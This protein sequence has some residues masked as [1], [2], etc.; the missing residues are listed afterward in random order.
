MF[1][2]K[3]PPLPGRQRPQAGP[4]R[5]NSAVFSYANNRSVRPASGNVGRDLKAQE[6]EAKKSPAAVRRRAQINWFKRGPTLVAALLAGLLLLNS[7]FLST[8]PRIV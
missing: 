7:L 2:K 6:K 5:R 8:Q 4:E 3:Q 1:G